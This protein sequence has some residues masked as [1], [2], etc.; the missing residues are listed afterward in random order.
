MRQAM[1]QAK[2][3]ETLHLHLES[4][5]HGRPEPYCTPT[6]QRPPPLAS[7]VGPLRNGSLRIG[8]LAN[9]RG[10]GKQLLQKGLRGT[11]QPTNS[12]IG[13]SQSPEAKRYSEIPWPSPQPG[14]PSPHLGRSPPRP[15]RRRPQGLYCLAKQESS[16]LR[17]PPFW[18]ILEFLTRAGKAGREV[19]LL[20]L[21]PLPSHRTPRPRTQAT[22][23]PAIGPPKLSKATFFPP[24]DIRRHPP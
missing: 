23:R 19:S 10:P 8:S 1:G 12:S 9:L 4:S 3:A 7:P 24:T 17:P 18:K 15:A 2:A 6:P 14:R 11:V 20:C 16:F 21:T 5:A 13:Y 22:K